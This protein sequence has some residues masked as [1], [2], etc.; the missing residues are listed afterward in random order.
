M[1]RSL[2]LLLVLAACAEPRAACLSR[3]EAGLRALDAE[4]AETES[5]LALGY[6]VAPRSRVTAGLAIC[7]GDSPVTL[8]VSG[9][10]PLH[11]RRR[12]IDPDTERARLRALLARRPAVAAAAAR[13]AAACPAP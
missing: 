13:S 8:C 7:A 12:A 1:R 2:G 11:E 5:A 4:I 3:A 10:R 6:R 9:E